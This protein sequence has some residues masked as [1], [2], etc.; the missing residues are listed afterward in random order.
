MICTLRKWQKTV[1]DKSEFIYS[2]SEISGN[3]L[4][5][6]NKWYRISI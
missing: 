4:T 2:A 6:T 5:K 1:I 3:M